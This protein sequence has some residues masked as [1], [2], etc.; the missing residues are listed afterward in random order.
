MYK[1]PT[2]ADNCR[3]Y[4]VGDIHGCLD[5]LDQLHQLIKDDVGDYHGQVTV[6]YLGDY[7]DRGD[8]SKGVVDYLLSDPL[9]RFKKI[10]L[11]GN[12]EQVLLDFLL[13][14][15]LSRACFWFRFGGLSTL[16]SYG[17]NIV[18]IPHQGMLHDVKKEFEIKI[19]KTH[20]LFFQQLLPYYEQDDYYFVHAGI[21]PCRKLEKQTLEDRLWIRNK[22]LDYKK[23]HEKMIV[24]GHSISDGPDQQPNR[25]GIDTGAYVTGKLTCLVLEQENISFLST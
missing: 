19:P 6:V 20:I 21:F 15:D 8:D 1:Q 22:F 23:K 10:F 3:V 2:V 5:L 9:P 18:G 12:H 13:G 7:V 17:V 11:L 14:S 4:C 24:H 16:A 25:I